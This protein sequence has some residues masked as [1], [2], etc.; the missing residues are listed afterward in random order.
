M[1]MYNTVDVFAMMACVHKYI[2]ACDGDSDF[3]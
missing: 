3:S 2:C 1:Y